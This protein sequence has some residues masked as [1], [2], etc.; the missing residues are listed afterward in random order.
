MLN[1]IFF[2]R[3]AS[4]IN[5]LNKKH[6]AYTIGGEE[7]GEENP[8]KFVKRFLKRIM[9][10]SYRESFSP[11]KGGERTDKGWGCLLRA[12]Q[13]L[14]AV[15]LLRCTSS[16]GQLPFHFR[17]KGPEAFSAYQ[18]V[19]SYF[20]DEN[21]AIFGIH[22]LNSET[23]AT[24]S[25]S[26]SLIRPS[27]A[28]EAIAILCNAN[29]FPGWVY[30]R[31]RCIR[32]TVILKKDVVAFLRENCVVLV[33]APFVCGFEK[34]APQYEQALKDFLILKSCCGLLIGEGLAAYY[35]F[36]YHKN[37][38]LCLDPH[39]VQKAFS[40][41]FGRG[42]RWGKLITVR[43]KKA[44]PSVL[45]GFYIHNETLLEELCNSLDEINRRLPLPLITVQ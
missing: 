33:L 14:L 1:F 21:D 30:P 35:A 29:P 17:G 39:F 25:S 6:H 23:A 22:R 34:V 40:S 31:V 3:S 10:F 36:G 43:I 27:A 5:H 26:E 18:I 28:A 15:A 13:M 44:E 2:F 41:Q 32:G 19:E 4:I 9:Y 42:H 20:R 8:N 16:D 12:A 7:S 45:V 37:N 24:R 11:L 38:Y